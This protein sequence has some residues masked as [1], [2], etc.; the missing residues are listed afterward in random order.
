M[1]ECARKV[2]LEGI[3]SVAPSQLPAA[4]DAVFNKCSSS[5]IIGEC[6]YEALTDFWEIQK[7]IRV[8]GAVITRVSVGSSFVD[9]FESNPKGVY[10]SSTNDTTIP[11]AVLLVSSLLV[12]VKLHV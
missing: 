6:S 1:A 11:H 7:A 4:C 2:D 5:Q 9:Y 8:N 12:L 3:R 10:N